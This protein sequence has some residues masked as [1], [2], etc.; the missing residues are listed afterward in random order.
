MIRGLLSAKVLAVG[1]AVAMMVTTVSIYAASIS[2]T[3][4][5][6]VGAGAVTVVGAPTSAVDVLYTLDCSTDNCPITYATAA[7]TPT[8]TTG[9]QYYNVTVNLKDASSIVATGTC[10]E[11]VAA[12][13]PKN[14]KTAVTG[15][16]TALNVVNAQ[17][18]I[19]QLAAAGVTA[20][21][22]G[23]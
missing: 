22:A 23:P 9:T 13:T 1:I 19:Q 7:W 17:V 11:T 20:C 12:A 21:A 14:S 8:W 2:T 10:Y 16:A 3:T 15:T 18:A 4:T 6:T 5:K